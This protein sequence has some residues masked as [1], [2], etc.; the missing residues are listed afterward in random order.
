MD[1]AGAKNATKPQGIISLH[2][3]T[4]AVIIPKLFKMSVSDS[5]S[6]VIWD[7][8]KAMLCLTASRHSLPLH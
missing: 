2:G 7:T 6:S 3:V 1:E 4:S 8:L 5:R